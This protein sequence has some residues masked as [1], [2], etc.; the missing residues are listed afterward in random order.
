MRRSVTCFGVGEGRP[1]GDRRQASF[2]Y[3]CGRTTLLVDCGDGMSCAFKAAGIGGEDVDAVLISHMHSDHVGGFPMFIQ[4]LWLQQ[5]RRPLPVFA[6]LQALTAL[7][8]WLEAVMLPQELIGFEIVW[9]PLGSGDRFRVGDVEVTVSPTSH[10]DS[11]R[12]SFGARYPA[13]AFE[14]FSFVIEGAGFRLAHTADIG[15]VRDLQPLLKKRP[16]L[17]VCELSHVEPEAICAALK[18]SPPARVAFVHVAREYLESP[19]GVEAR[20]HALLDP[21]PFSVPRDGEI[22]AF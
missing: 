20:L 16:D 14:A 13:T 19:Q 17:L 8:A 11:L 1:S 21:V 18:A 9:R 10:L 6:P 2:L 22:L 7:K 12:Q 15:D 4:S 3:R 5:R